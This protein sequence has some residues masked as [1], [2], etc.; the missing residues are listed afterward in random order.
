M[1][2][3]QNTVDAVRARLATWRAQAQAANAPAQTQWANASPP[4]QF[5]PQPTP[6]MPLAV[7]QPRGVVEGA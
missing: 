2:Q 1:P 6:P 5:E 3:E 7:K 4:A